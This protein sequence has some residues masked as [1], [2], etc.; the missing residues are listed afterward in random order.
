M[1]ANQIAKERY[2]V[3]IRMVFLALLSANVVLVIV[4]MISGI[5]CMKMKM[6]SGPSL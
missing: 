2:V 1:G 5:M 3:L 4:Q 6:M